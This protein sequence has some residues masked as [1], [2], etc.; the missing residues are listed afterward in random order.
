[1]QGHAF[2]HLGQ[3]K[4]AEKAYVKAMEVSE[5]AWNKNRKLDPAK[6][7]C[8]LEQ[9]ASALENLHYLYYQ[10]RDLRDD[11]KRRE[12]ERQLSHIEKLLGRGYENMESSMQESFDI[13]KLRGGERQE[14]ENR[15][16]K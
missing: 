12:I 14:I 15:P 3:P 16:S 1:M 8:C 13:G 7:K 11:D 10:K 9:Q 5:A 2:D 4:E 6:S